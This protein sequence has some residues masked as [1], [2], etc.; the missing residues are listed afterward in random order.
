MNPQTRREDSVPK[1]NLIQ[2]IREAIGQEMRRDPTVLLLG[3]SVQGSLFGTGAGLVAEFGPDRVID[4]PLAE[5]ATS[6]AVVGMALTGYRPIYE[7]IASFSLAGFEEMFLMA[8]SWKMLHDQPVP[9]TMLLIGGGGIGSPDHSII[10]TGIAFQCAGMKIAVP[11]N[12]YDAKGLFASAVRDPNP[13]LFLAHTSTLAESMEVPDEAY[14][15]P[16]GQAS[17]LV[18]GSDI[19]V[20]ASSHATK[21]AVEAAGVLAGEFS[22][23]V[24]DLRTIEPLDME[25]VMV[26]VGKTRRAVVVDGDINRGG[27][28]AELAA[29]ISEAAFGV[30]TAPVQ[31]VAR[32]PV[33][34]PGG[35]ANDMFIHPSVDGVVDAI[36]NTCKYA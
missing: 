1:R 17:V 16:F 14:V 34:I 10:P 11:S 20:V 35:R 2:A 5:S 9:L 3:Q 36:R 13:V 22:V 28:A 27:V 4:T 7:H 12:A 32:M 24:I 31:R 30:L 21:L 8:P 19:T 25:T 33:P 26:S 23:E 18:E 6:G 29:Q 15:V